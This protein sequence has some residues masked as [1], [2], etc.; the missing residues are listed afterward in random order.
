MREIKI[1]VL[2]LYFTAKIAEM[3]IR[4]CKWYQEIIELILYCYNKVLGMNILT[5]LF[6]SIHEP[7]RSVSYT[8]LDVY[9]RQPRGNPPDPGEPVPITKLRGL[10]G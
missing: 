2:E 10:S 3:K 8:H 7:P 5:F 4:N 1:F 9:K 6:G